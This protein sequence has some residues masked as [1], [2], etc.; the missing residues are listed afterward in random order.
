MS[1]ITAEDKDYMD[2]IGEIEKKQN[3]SEENEGNIWT[4]TNR[5]TI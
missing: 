1:E 3:K 5:K 4:E 2:S